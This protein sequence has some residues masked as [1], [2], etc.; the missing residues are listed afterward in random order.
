MMNGIIRN[1]MGKLWKI[2][3]QGVMSSKQWSGRVQGQGQSP[4]LLKLHL[5]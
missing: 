5:K 3:N 2:L 4:T 1:A